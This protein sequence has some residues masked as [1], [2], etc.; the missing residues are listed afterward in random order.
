MVGA[1][2]GSTEV[3]V[4]DGNDGR[5]RWV[6]FAAGITAGIILLAGVVGFLVLW[7]G[8]PGPTNAQGWT[9]LADMPDR[10]GEMATAVAEG[11]TGEELIVIGGRL[12][13]ART[14][15]AVRIYDARSDTWRARPPLPAARHHAGAAAL[16]DDTLVVAGGAEGRSGGPES[17]VWLYDPDGWREGPALPEPRMA[18]AMVAVDEAVYVIGGR[19]ASART[20][21]FE[22]ETWSAAAE[23]P[24]PREHL[25]AAVLDGEIWV[26]GG[27][28]DG[29]QSRVDV[30]DPDTDRWREGPS[31]PT[32][33][34]APAVAVVDDTLVV[35]GGED[36]SLFGGGVVEGAWRLSDDARSWQPLPS[37]PLAVHGAAA[38]VVDGQLVIAGGA[39]RHGAWSV[40]SWTATTQRLEA[41]AL[42]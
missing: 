12:G 3:S 33:T 15:S 24:G 36:P 13:V 11:F 26:V 21:V 34:S 1:G 31:L 30:Y 23:L 27:R 5:T 16:P 38:G 35:V 20:F 17:D 8:S 28:D 2:Q 41:D 19:G 29:A 18:H 32:A 14:S 25:G 4:L 22:D 9:L 42:R 40:L 10:R 6:L 7:R 37:P 39:S